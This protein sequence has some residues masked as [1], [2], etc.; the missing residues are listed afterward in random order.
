MVSHCCV[1]SLLPTPPTLKDERAGG[2]CWSTLIKI[3]AD[4]NISWGSPPPPIY[5]AGETVLVLNRVGGPPTLCGGQCVLIVTIY[6]WTLTCCWPQ[7]LLCSKCLCVRNI[8]SLILVL[9][10]IVLCIVL[11][12]TLCPIVEGISIPSSVVDHRAHC[13]EAAD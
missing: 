2:S 1:L 11:C 6:P 5:I 7:G 4:T 10:C 8:P 13:A 9:F 12:I 3:V